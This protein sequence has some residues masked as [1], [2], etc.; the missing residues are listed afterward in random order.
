MNPEQT[1]RPALREPLLWLVIGLPLAAVVA[2]ILTLVIAIR[3]GGADA[4]PDPVRRTAQIQQLDLGPDHLAR[5]ASLTGNLQIEADGRMRLQLDGEVAQAVL[6]LQ[7]IHPAD[8]AQDRQIAL[9]RDAAAWSGSVS[10]I[11]TG[12]D[13]RLQLMSPDQGWR[14]HGRWHRGQRSIH[15]APALEPK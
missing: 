10:D 4:L 1:H 13:W 7:L 9:H 11:D 8:A 3:A 2:G 5:D 6:L 12:H 15:L 14:L